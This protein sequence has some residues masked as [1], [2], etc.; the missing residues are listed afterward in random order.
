M[1]FPLF[2]IFIFISIQF[3]SI[4]FYSTSTVQRINNQSKSNDE[5][6]VSIDSMIEVY[7]WRTHGVKKKIHSFA[8]AMIHE[9]EYSGTV[10]QVINKWNQ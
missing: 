1:H 2:H 7:R 4:L 8:L 5:E 10:K 9:I 3:N 6:E